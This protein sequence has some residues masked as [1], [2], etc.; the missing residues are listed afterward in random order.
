MLEQSTKLC[1]I[2]KE[3][4]QLCNRKAQS[5]SSLEG[6]VRDT[7]IQSSAFNDLHSLTVFNQAGRTRRYHSQAADLERF[8]GSRLFLNE[9]WS[10]IKEIPHPLSFTALRELTLGI[11]LLSPLKGYPPHLQKL[12]TRLYRLSEYYSWAH[13]LPSLKVL[14]L[15]V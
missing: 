3:L 2:S 4:K 10:W 14:D 13:Y 9:Q 11:T 12:V 6:I 1:S 7:Y 15:T 8:V 5:F